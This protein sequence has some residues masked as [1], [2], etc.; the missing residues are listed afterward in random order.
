MTAAVKN[1]ESSTVILESLSS[2]LKAGKEL[3]ETVLRDDSVA[4]NVAASARN[5]SSTTSNL[6]RRGLW[7]IFCKQKPPETNRPTAE[8]LA[9]PH[10]PFR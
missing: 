8:V 7:K 6:S 4:T 3:A 1:I 5:L 2:D 10:D 9:A